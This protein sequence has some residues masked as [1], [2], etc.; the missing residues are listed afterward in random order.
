M[1]IASSGGQ[2]IYYSRIISSS[3]S[4]YLKQ[5]GSQT[6]YDPNSSLYREIRALFISSLTSAKSLIY[7]I[8]KGWTDLA[9]LDFSTNPTTI[10]Y[11]KTLPYMDVLVFGMTTG[12]FISDTIYYTGTYSDWFY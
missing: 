9:S 11:K 1:V 8:K 4:P 12:L 5:T 10:T 7:D 2:I 6:Y 3:S